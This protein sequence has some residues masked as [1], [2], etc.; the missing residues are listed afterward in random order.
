MG[1]KPSFSFLRV[2]YKLIVFGFPF[3]GLAVLWVLMQAPLLQEND[4]LTL[5]LTVDLLFTIP[6]VYFL[7]IRKTDIPKITVFPLMLLGLL[8]GS[9]FLPPQ[10]Q[11][12]LDLFKYWGLPLIELSVLI[13][14]GLKVSRALKTYTTFKSLSPDFYEVLK[15]VCLQEFPKKLAPLLISEVAVFYYGFVRWKKRTILPNEYSYHQKSG[16]PSLLMGLIMV[17]GIETVAMHFVLAKWSTVAAWI[18]TGVSIYSAIQVFGFAKSL[19]QR[20]I[21][22]SPDGLVLRYGILN[23]TKLSYHQIDA[24]VLSTESFKKEKYNRKISPFGDLESHNVLIHLKQLGTLEGLYGFNKK[25][26]TLAL[27]LDEPQQFKAQLDR[28][29]AGTQPLED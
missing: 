17:I 29:I 23:E 3:G 25:F 20:P 16:T 8:L 7:L 4:A 21:C 6:L 12:Y 14:I 11:T 27:H 18:L 5:A 13:L 26:K 9:Y 24:V 28:T 15:K 2:P 19:S 10:K 1:S 22:C